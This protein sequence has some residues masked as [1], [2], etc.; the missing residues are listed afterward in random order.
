MAALDAALLEMRK[1]T[2][3]TPHGAAAWL[4]A[5][6]FQAL[7]RQLAKHPALDRLIYDCADITGAVLAALRHNITWVRADPAMVTP[8]LQDLATRHGSILL[9]ERP[10]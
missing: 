3:I 4:G 10:H 9:T 8:A 5:A 7:Q 6:Y 2:L 1:I